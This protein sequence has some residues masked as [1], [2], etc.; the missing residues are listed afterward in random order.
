VLTLALDTSGDTCLVAV[1]TVDGETVTV[2]AEHRFRHERRL[3]ER[4]PA[5]VEF[6]LRD[7]GAVLTD[8]DAFVVG[9]GPGSFTGVRVGVTMAK[10]WALA[11]SKPLFGVS[12]FDALAYPAVE[13][14]PEA[15]VAV[16]APTG[17]GIV[18]GA[19]Y[20]GRLEPVRPPAVLAS[21]TVACLAREAVGVN[22]PVLLCGEA[23]PSV[24]DAAPESVRVYGEPISARA[25]LLL[26]A[27]RMRAGDADDPDALVPLYITPTPVG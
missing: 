3:S 22:T 7:T 25:L 15:A 4:L 24:R 18:V 6:A 8:V 13:A 2:R 1:G 10:L 11:L 19:F 5:I 20:H 26:A 16:V 23:A 17:R 14:T 12:S 9:T 21:G 27:P